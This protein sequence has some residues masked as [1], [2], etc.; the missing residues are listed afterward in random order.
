M[1]R[2]KLKKQLI[3]DRDHYYENRL[4]ELSEKKFIKI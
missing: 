2:F 1:K 3:S 4:C